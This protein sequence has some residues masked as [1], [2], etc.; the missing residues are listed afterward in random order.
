MI[1]ALFVQPRGCYYGLPNVEPWGLPERD[2]RLYQGIYPVIAHPPCA[3]WG[4]FWRGGL[5][6]NSKRYQLGDDNGCFAAA[7]RSVRTWGGVL[8]HPA[9]SRAWDAFHITT[10]PRWGGWVSAGLFHPGAYT[11]CVE[12]GHY[13]HRARK[14]TWLY[15]CGYQ[16]VLPELIWGASEVPILGTRRRVGQAYGNTQVMSHREREATPVEFRNVLIDIAMQCG[17]NS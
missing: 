5:R 16:G 1:A 8:E 3:R 15:V 10:P 11:C 14:R 2:A 4:R 9:D 13:G 7:L 17:G 12:Q 6:R